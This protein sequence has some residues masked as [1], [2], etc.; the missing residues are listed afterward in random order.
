MRDEEES[1]CEKKAPGRRRVCIECGKLCCDNCY[2]PHIIKCMIPEERTALLGR[3]KPMKPNK[4]VLVRGLRR[5][6]P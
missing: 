6:Y 2:E 4:G 5:V 1:C 3:G